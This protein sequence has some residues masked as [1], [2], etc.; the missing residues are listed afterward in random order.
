MGAAD[1]EGQVT[2]EQAMA[3]LDRVREGALYPAHVVDFALTLTGDLSGET[4][5][6]LWQVPAGKTAGRW[7]GYVPDKVDVRGMLGASSIGL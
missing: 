5:E 4:E 2:H 1:A 3:L 7:C 6:I